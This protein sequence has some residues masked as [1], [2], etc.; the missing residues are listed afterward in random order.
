MK[1][2]LVA[3][4]KEIDT[5]LNL[6]PWEE[7]CTDEENTMYSNMANLKESMFDAGHRD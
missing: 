3:L 4:Y 1:E 2:R 7:D 5:L 6:A